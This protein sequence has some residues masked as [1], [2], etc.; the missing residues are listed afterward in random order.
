MSPLRHLWVRIFVGEGQLGGA[1]VQSGGSQ[2]TGDSLF[3]YGA[4]TALIG[5][6]L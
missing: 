6:E 3:E 5:R 2:P 1:S 4:P